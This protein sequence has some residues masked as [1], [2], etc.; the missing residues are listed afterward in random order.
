MPQVLQWFELSTD[1]ECS[2]D[3]FGSQA[4]RLA[5]CLLQ[6]MLTTLQQQVSSVSQVGFTT[7]LKHMHA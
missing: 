6:Q 1:P 7:W 5:A 2:S 3:D 4:E